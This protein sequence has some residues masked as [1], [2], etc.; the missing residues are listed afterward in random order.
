MG[1]RHILD[2]TSEA[3][4][5]IC[6]DL[7]SAKYCYVAKMRPDVK[8]MTTKWVEAMYTQWINGEDVDPQTFEAEHRMPVFY[9]LKISVT[10][11]ADGMMSFHRGKKRENINRQ[12]SCGAQT[13]RRDMSGRI[14]NLPPGPHV[15]DHAPRCGCT[16]G[17]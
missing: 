3:T 9:K 1:A 11:I 12:N 8:V 4:H 10:G 16:H 13:N 14:S 7:F 15:R 2:L 17:R 5:L 6:G